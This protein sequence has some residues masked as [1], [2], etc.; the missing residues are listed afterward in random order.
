ML[1]YI[2]QSQSI[3]DSQVAS[4]PFL[5]S[6]TIHG[7]WGWYHM[8]IL[9]MAS[10]AIQHLSLLVVTR[11]QTF[12]AKQILTQVVFI[13]TVMA[14][15]LFILLLPI[16]GVIILIIPKTFLQV[17]GRLEARKGVDK[18]DMVHTILVKVV[19]EA[20][21]DITINISCPQYQQFIF[22]KLLLQT[23]LPML[24]LW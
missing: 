10:L 9:D 12:L 24:F 13:W 18:L 22:N 20:D 16:L 23:P 5:S 4:N 19:R 17:A 14:L 7:G 15:V 3:R 1:S 11:T 2:V 6:A 21:M 8:V